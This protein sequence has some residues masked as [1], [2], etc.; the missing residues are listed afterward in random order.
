MVG[1]ESSSVCAH[2]CVLFWTYVL[3]L[4]KVQNKAIRPHV[5]NRDAK[6]Q[7]AEHPPLDVTSPLFKLSGR[8]Q[9]KSNHHHL[10]HT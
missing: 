8:L 3:V 7:P 5:H 1:F 9:G 10:G 2:L 4:Y 6:L